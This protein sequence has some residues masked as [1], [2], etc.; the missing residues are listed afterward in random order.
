M[1]MAMI[2]QRIVI[3]KTLVE[4]STI[5]KQLITRANFICYKEILLIENSLED[6]VG[7]D[8]VQIKNETKPRESP[9]DSSTNDDEIKRTISIKETLPQK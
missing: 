5:F 4:Q 7:Q 3:M 2:A 9:I 6:D 1:T 8:D